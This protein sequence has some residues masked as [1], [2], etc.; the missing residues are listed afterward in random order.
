M[1]ELCG[2]PQ[3]CI[4]KLFWAGCNLEWILLI[5]IPLVQDRSLDLLTRSPA[6]TIVLRMPPTPNFK[7]TEI[8][9]F[10]MLWEQILYE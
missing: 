7:Y 2:R 5:I 1:K 3:F 6:A 9:Q 8:K 4:L 10:S